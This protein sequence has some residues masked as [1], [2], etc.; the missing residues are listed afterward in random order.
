MVADYL[1]GKDKLRG[2]FVGQIMK[3]T[4]GKGNPSLVNQL[5]TQQLAQKV[6]ENQ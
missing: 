1:G 2:W 4:R 3:A 5:L 6:R